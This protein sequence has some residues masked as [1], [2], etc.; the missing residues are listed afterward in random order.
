MDRKS[1]NSD[2]R[3]GGDQS[4][5]AE[6]SNVIAFRQRSPAPS[7][8][9]EAAKID[10]DTMRLLKV[11]DEIDAVIL[12]HLSAGAVEPRDL[13]GVLSHRL[14]TLMRHLEEKDK[15]VD[16]CQQV[17]AKQAAVDE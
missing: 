15:L 2:G 8:P 11:A 12:K 4:D 3:P 1:K 5:P 13:A 10:G 7:A 6:A 9:K 14:G 16:V 17:I